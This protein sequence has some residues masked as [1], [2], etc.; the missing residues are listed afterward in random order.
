MT[1][2]ADAVLSPTLVGSWGLVA[3]RPWP[4]CHSAPD[5]PDGA[6]RNF[7]RFRTL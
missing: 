1:D 2:E 3:D 6:T 7:R 4:W 5:L